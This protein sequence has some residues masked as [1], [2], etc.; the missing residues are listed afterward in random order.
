LP[1]ETQ[2]IDPLTQL[3]QA[4][5][6]GEVLAQ[7]KLGVMFDEGDGVQSDVYEAVKWYRKA[8]EN[9]NA[10]AQVAWV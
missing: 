10:E 8:A 5:E 1:K 9:G 2:T 6:S 7:L 4:A 3:R